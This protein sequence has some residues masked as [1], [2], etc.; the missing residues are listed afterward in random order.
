MPRRSTSN[1]ENL[2]KSVAD[3]YSCVGIAKLL[4]LMALRKLVRLDCRMETQAYG[5]HRF[6][7]LRSGRAQ[8]SIAPLRAGRKTRTDSPGTAA[9]VG[10]PRGRG[11]Y[12][13]GDC[14]KAVG[15][16]SPARYRECD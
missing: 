11:R 14:R 10:G 6:R 1:G 2:K 9:A 7:G 15:Q 4:N 13:G 5:L 12:S 16:R 3:V 8:L